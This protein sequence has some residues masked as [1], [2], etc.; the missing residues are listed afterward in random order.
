MMQGYLDDLIT[1][2]RTQVHASY[3]DDKCAPPKSFIALQVLL[4]L[5]QPYSRLS[6]KFLAQARRT[7]LP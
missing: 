1:S 6:L 5:V 7:P 2:I 3:I 4:G